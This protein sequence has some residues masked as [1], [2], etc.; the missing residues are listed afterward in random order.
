MISLV[1]QPLILSAEIKLCLCLSTERKREIAV[2][3]SVWKGKFLDRVYSFCVFSP[4]KMQQITLGQKREK[5][6]EEQ[7]VLEYSLCLWTHDERQG[8]P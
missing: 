7:Y 5:S 6:S 3:L 8:R 4:N 1:L 2:F